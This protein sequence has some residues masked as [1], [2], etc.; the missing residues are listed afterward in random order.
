MITDESK[1]T[2]ES[3]MVTQLDQLTAKKLIE[4]EVEVLKS[5]TLMG[6]VVD[7]LRLYATFY[8]E[9]EVAKKSAYHS[10]PVLIEAPHPESLKSVKKV[11]FSYSDKDKQV[12]IGSKR[13]PLNQLVQTDYGELKFVPNRTYTIKAANPLYFAI[14][15]PATAVEMYSSK[16]N[17]IGSRTSTVISLVQKDEVPTRAE[18]ILNEL[19][20]VYNRATIEEKTRLAST[21][22]DF[23]DKRLKIVEDEL[24]DIEKR[25]QTYKSSQQA[26]D[27]GRQGE[28]YLNI[29]KMSVRRTRN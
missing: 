1:G 26:V 6:E 25:A 20:A 4:N 27:I 5:K 7:N 24:Q 18:D 13:Y 19:I 2:V 11:A 21:T 10:T 22:L 14:V 23:V 28:M 29:L 9:G 12:V 3:E 16:L 8:E 17:V 15:R